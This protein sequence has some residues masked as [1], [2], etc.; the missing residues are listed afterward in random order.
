[1]LLAVPVDAAAAM[2]KGVA[3][4]EV[5]PFLFMSMVKAE[6]VGAVFVLPWQD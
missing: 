4:I 2:L 1:M 6:P 3:K 5:V